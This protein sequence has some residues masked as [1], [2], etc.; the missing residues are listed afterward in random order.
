VQRVGL[1]LD[2]ELFHLEAIRIVA[3]ILLGDVVA[4][5]AFLAC[6]GDLGADIAG[7]GHCILTSM[8]HTIVCMSSL[9]TTGTAYLLCLML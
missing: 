1:A 3:T 8:K 5:F 9:L 4:V 2:A 7:L 6:Q